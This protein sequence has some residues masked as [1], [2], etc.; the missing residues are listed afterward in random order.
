MGESARAETSKMAAADMTEEQ[1]A[2]FKEAFALFDKDGNGK[3][4]AQELG[5][6]MKNLGQNPTEAELDDM[7]KEVDADASGVIEF[8]EFLNLMA[9]KMSSGDS[10]EETKEAFKVFDKDGSGF[11][12]KAELKK[13]MED[14]GEKLSEEGID[15]MIKEADTDDDGKIN[16]EEF[17]NM[18]GSK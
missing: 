18:M 5:T 1:I 11:I 10:V 7:I 6:V 16:Y 13:V 15:E 8:P 9:K 2:E 3:I 14:L 12:E 4:S 17:A